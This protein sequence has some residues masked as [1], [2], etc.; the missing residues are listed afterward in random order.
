MMWG[1]RPKWE[2]SRLAASGGVALFR[3]PCGWFCVGGRGKWPAQFLLLQGSSLLVRLGFGHVAKR[4]EVGRKKNPIP[5][6]PHGRAVGMGGSGLWGD[7]D[8]TNQ[9]SVNDAS[10]GRQGGDNINPDPVSDILIH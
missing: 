3:A 9:D 1:R 10:W 6:D 8:H 2:G 4:S 7:G 5:Q